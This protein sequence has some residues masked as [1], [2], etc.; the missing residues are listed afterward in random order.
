MFDVEKHVFNPSTVTRSGVHRLEDRLAS[1]TTQG[2]Q[3]IRLAAGAV[4]VLVRTGNVGYEGVVVAVGGVTGVTIVVGITVDITVA[5][6]RAAADT[7]RGTSVIRR[8]GG[9]MRSVEASDARIRL[10]GGGVGVGWI[11]G[12]SPNVGES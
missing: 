1:V 6:A 2:A 9:G 8:R 12:W 5:G 4:A 10:V 11:G 7:C 3:N